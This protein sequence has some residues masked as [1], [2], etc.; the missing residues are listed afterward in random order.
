MCLLRHSYALCLALSLIVIATF[1]INSPEQGEDFLLFAMFNVLLWCNRHRFSLRPVSAH[2]LRLC[3]QTVMDSKIGGC[4]APLYM[5][6]STSL[7]LDSNF[8]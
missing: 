5:A 3:Q 2:P 8:G 7:S 1:V 6:W 4:C